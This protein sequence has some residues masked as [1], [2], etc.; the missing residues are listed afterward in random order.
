MSDQEFLEFAPERKSELIRGEFIVASPASYRHEWVFV[1]LLTVPNSF[2]HKH[3]LGVVLGSRTAVRLRIRGEVYE[4]DICFVRRER[5]GLITPTYI[6]GPPDL[7]VEIL[8]RSTEHDDRVVKKAGYERAGVLEYWLI[9]PERPL[10]EF[11]RLTGASYSPIP[12]DEEG[13]FRSQTVPGFWL[14][15]AWFWPDSG[16]PNPLPALRELGVI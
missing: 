9:H 6:D 5:V 16:D 10:A 4:P 8:S 2:V 13:I 14:K 15:P 3:D 7:A 11:Y 12:T 1:F